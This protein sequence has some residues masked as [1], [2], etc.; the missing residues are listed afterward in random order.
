MKNRRRLAHDDFRHTV[1][2]TEG[3]VRRCLKCSVVEVVR[4]GL[5]FVGSMLWILVV[6]CWLLALAADACRVAGHS[7]RVLLRTVWGTPKLDF[8]CS[9]SLASES[10]ELTINRQFFE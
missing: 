1:V 2:N 4:T 8:I 3:A 6:G 10:L 5:C 7:G 9:L